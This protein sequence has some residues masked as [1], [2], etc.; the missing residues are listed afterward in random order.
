MRRR[1][2]RRRRLPQVA[3]ANAAAPMAAQDQAIVTTGTRAA[4]PSITNNQEANVDEGDIVKA[5]GDMLVILRRGRLFTVSLAGG[6]QRPVDSINAFPPG[7]AGQDAWYDEMLLDGDRVVVVGY[8]YERGGTEINRFRLDPTGHLRF[9]DAY[10]LRSNDY[11]SDRNYASRLIGHRL[12]FYTPLQL[13][14]R[15]DNPLEALPG[16]RKWR[17]GLGRD[18]PFRPIATARQIYIVPTM[19]DDR[20]AQIDTLHSVTTCDLTAPVLDCS[21]I[22]VLGPASRTFYVS[23]DAVYLWVS[24][25]SRRERKAGEAEA[26]LYRLP[27]GPE[28]PSAIATRGAPIDQFSFRADE[29]DGVLNVLL[30][31]EGQGDAMFGPEVSAGRVALLRVPIDAF[32]DGSQDAPAAY[33]RRAA[34]AAWA[35]MVVPQPLRRRSRPLRRPAPMARTPRTRPC[36][37]RRIRGGRVSEIALDHAI[38]RIEPLGQDALVVGSGGAGGARLHR[39]RAAAGRRAGTRRRLH[40]GSGRARARLAATPSSSVPGRPTAR[41]GCSACRSRAPPEPAYQRFFGSAASMLFLRRDARRFAQGGRARRE[42]QDVVDDACQA[43]CVDWYGNAR[44]IFLG[45]RV[46]ALLGY[47]LVEGRLDGGG[48]IREIGRVNFAPRMRALRSE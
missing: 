48:R 5:R 31:K 28:P 34:D 40:P 42:A 19:R 39:D 2:R 25:W 30:R 1:R 41:P 16:L 24:E 6:A 21:A 22:G 8:S 11:Y 15:G 45:N 7:D 23:A 3:A 38:E 44:P 12:I 17:P 4:A 20:D 46:F 18:A 47:E 14:W 33:Y 43:S 37:S 35:A 32:G 26:F 29:S 36:S 9:E 10:H 13:G 27:F